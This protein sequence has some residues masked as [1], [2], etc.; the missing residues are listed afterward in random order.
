MTIP[1]RESSFQTKQ[2]I[3][4]ATLWGGERVSLLKIPH[5][6]V[7]DLCIYLSE[8]ILPNSGVGKDWADFPL[9]HSNNNFELR[10]FS[11]CFLIRLTINN[12]ILLHPLHLCVV[13]GW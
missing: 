5:S 12:Q 7:F 13:L 6:K 1:K 2:F 11:F 10:T 3:C 4:T 8:L 9:T